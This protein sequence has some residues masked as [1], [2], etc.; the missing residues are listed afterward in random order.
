MTASQ[1]DFSSLIAIAKKTRLAALKLAVLSTE[2]RNQ[3]I[4]AI[5]QALESAQS[6]ILS[7]NLADCQTAVGIAKPLYKRLQLDEHKLRDAI[8]ESEM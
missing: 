2:A 5:A 8:A 6:E 1:D 7:A 4:V 3:A